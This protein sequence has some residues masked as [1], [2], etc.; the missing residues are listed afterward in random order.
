MLASTDLPGYIPEYTDRFLSLFCHRYDYIWAAH[1]APGA[2]TNWHTNSDHPLSDRMIGSGNYLY[3]VRFGQHCSYAMLDIDKNSPY[4]PSRD[5]FAVG[6]M[7]AALDKL[8]LCSQL[9][10]TSSYSGGLHVYF[11]FELLAQP[12][13][14]WQLAIALEQTLQKAGFL[15]QDGLLECFPNVRNYDPDGPTLFKG[16]RLPLQAGSY[17][18]DDDWQLCHSTPESFTQRWDR[19]AIRNAI[20]QGAID[21][22]IKQ[23]GVRNQRLSFK[24]KKF[25][26]DL[27]TEVENGWTSNGQTNY[28]LGRIAMRSYIFG[29]FINRAK[30]LTGERLIMD[31]VRVAIA[32]PGYTDYCR[33]QAE[34]WNRAE[35]WARCVENSRY[36]PYQHGKPKVEK[37]LEDAAELPQ[38]YNKFVEER[39]R[40]RLCFALADL[41]NKDALPFSISNRFDA[42]TLNYGFSGQTLYRHRDLWHPEGFH[43]GD[44]DGDGEGD[45]ENFSE[46]KNNSKESSEGGALGAPSLENR[47]S[48]LE[49]TER[50]ALLDKGKRA[51]WEGWNLE[52]G[53]NSPPSEGLRDRTLDKGGG[54]G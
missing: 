52:T 41:L 16:H 31:V 3:G 37:P 1:A 17:L 20:D 49:L 9:A 50:K 38:S 8:G 7:S 19:T 15:V 48:L 54:D 40:E 13:A 51:F 5:P 32:L 4:H 39:A 11:P 29:H 21:R 6:K 33:H 23:S 53:C 18:I 45:G 22:A 26:N 43:S 10:I 24:A 2:P 25:L 30:P 27:N 35:E 14:S 47:T 34:I 44:G 12:V 28:I 42:L 36:Y 46:S